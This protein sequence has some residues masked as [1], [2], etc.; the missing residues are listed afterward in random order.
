MK[1]FV[2]WLA[3][4]RYRMILLAAALVLIPGVGIVGQAIVA[5]A[6]LRRG[7]AEGL[8]IAVAASALIVV[9]LTLAGGAPPMRAGFVVLTWLPALALGALLRATRSLSLTV[10][11]ST[12]V[13][14]VAVVAAFVFGDPVSGGREFLARFGAEV[15]GELS[16]EAIAAVSLILTGA[17]GAAGLLVSLGALF[18]GRAWQAAIDRPGGF[19]AE[20]RQ[21]RLGK[22]VLAV[23]SVVFVVAGVSGLPMLQNLT[24]VLLSAYLLQGLAVAH[25]FVATTAGG[26]GT[27]WLGAIYVALVMLMQFAV[28]VVAGVGFLD[29]WF[30]FRSRL[31]HR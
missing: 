11:I 23:A 19:G 20:F 5:F 18:I 26:L 25:A 27:L 4:R 17:L 7:P 24:L 3:A 22:V 15:T 31:A 13:V 6:V 28:P 21:L 1:G 12:V 29:S 16:P 8:F 10:Q 14:L 2:E 9:A 30:N